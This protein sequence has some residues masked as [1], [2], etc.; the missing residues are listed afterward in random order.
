M[1]ESGAARYLTLLFSIENDSETYIAEHF[2]EGLEPVCNWVPAEKPCPWTKVLSKEYPDARM[3]P[4]Y[5]P[6]DSSRDAEGSAPCGGIL[7]SYNN[8]IQFQ[9]GSS[10][11]RKNKTSCRDV[12]P[13]WPKGPEWEVDAP[14]GTQ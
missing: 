1:A 7:F 13:A 11:T 5:P 6:L 9:G 12:Q 4:P 8:V 3:P 10:S 14:R 2:R